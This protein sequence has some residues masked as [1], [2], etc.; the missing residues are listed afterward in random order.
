MSVSRLPGNRD[1]F[2]SLPGC[3][4]RH[5]FHVSADVLQFW[6]RIVQRQPDAVA[7]TDCATGESWT[8]ARLDGESDR[9]TSE[10]IPASHLRRKRVLLAEPNSGRWLVGFLGLLKSGAVPVPVDPTESGHVRHEAARSTGAA[11]IVVGGAF[12]PTGI[13][14]TVRRNDVCLIKQTSGSTGAPK[15]CL[16]SHAAMIADGRQI[17]SSM[18]IRA[19]D[20]NL[21][22]IP[23]GHSYGLGNIVMPLLIQGTPVAIASGPL[24]ELLAEDCRNAMPTVFPTVPAILRVLARSGV[25]ANA[26]RSLRLVISAGSLLRMEDAQTFTEKFG[27]PV[28]GFYGSSETGGITYDRTGTATATGRS[29]GTPMDGVKLRFRGRHSFAV[30]SAA[31]MG[32]GTFVP[33]D[34]GELNAQGELVLLGRSGRMVK[35]GAKRIDLGEIESALRRLKEVED[36]CAFPHPD[37][38]GAVAAVVATK[39]KPLEIRRAL[40]RY[41]V[42]WKIPHRVVA[43]DALPLTARGKIDQRRAIQLAAGKPG[44]RP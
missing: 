9:F 31:V 37:R 8:F 33:K 38:D 36:A 15:A 20:V 28:H 42:A 35:I 40:S 1:F 7:L 11:G 22:L 4:T 2:D 25:S 6:R 10:T 30:E 34:R 16:F 17:C 29:V 44:R 18:G 5:D 26:F 27:L 39:R 24:P 43:V 13:G 21:G 19:G 14:R 41:L 32:R 3:W 23:F 12:E